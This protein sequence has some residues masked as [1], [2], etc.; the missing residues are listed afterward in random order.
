M[1]NIG[2]LKQKTVILLHN[3]ALK[4]MKKRRERKSG[5]VLHGS[6]ARPSRQCPKLYEF[7]SQAD[8]CRQW[9]QLTMWGAVLGTA[10]PWHFAHAHSHTHAVRSF[11]AGGGGYLGFEC[12][13]VNV[14]KKVWK[15]DDAC[16][17]V[18]SVKNINIPCAYS[19]ALKMW[20]CWTLK[21]GRGGAEIAVCKLQL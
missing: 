5:F 9:T 12:Q 6:C 18:W 1:Y 8:V 4:W 20:V 2:L 10:Q 21:V 11:R 17:C 13:R 15:I 3:P 19:I 14:Y 16:V 7:H